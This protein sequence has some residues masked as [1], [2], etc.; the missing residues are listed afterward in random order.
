MSY[1]GKFLS[2]PPSKPLEVHING[3]MSKTVNRTASEVARVAA[4]F[5]DLGKLNPNFQRKLFGKVSE[6]SNHSLLSAV[7]L[8]CFVEQNRDTLKQWFGENA[9]LKFKMVLA[10]IIAHHGNLPNFREM[11][12]KD[13]NSAIDLLSFLS[14][15]TEETIPAAGFLQVI[16]EEKFASFSILKILEHP[17]LWQLF[18]FGE[19]EENTW[20]IYAL[21]YFLE[22]QFSFASLIESD[23]RDAGN[24]EDF[25]LPKQAKLTAAELSASID[26]TFAGL[27]TQSELNTL[28]TAI[29]EEAVASLKVELTKGSRVFSLTAPT[30]AGKTYTLLALAKEIQR[31]RPE[32][33]VLYALPFLS[34]IEQV[35]DITRGLFAEE[36]AVL[37]F[38][39]KSVNTEIERAQA[40]LDGDQSNEKVPALLKQD[41]AANTFDHPFIVTTFVQFFETLMSNHNSTL[42]K[43]PNF[44]KR[45]FLIDEIQALP[46]RLYLFFAGW[47]D[48]FCRKFDAYCV[49]ST[50]TMPHW[51]IA[52]FKQEARHLFK[53]YQP[54]VELLEARKF[55]DQKPFNRYRVDWMGGDSIGLDDLAAEVRKQPQS[56]LVILNT[57]DDTKQL[58]EKLKD[59]T[60]PCILLNTHFI[61]QDRRAKIQRAKSLLSQGEKLTLISTQLI[62]AGVDVDFPVIY[63]DLCPLP[64]LI[65]SAGRC[66]RNGR[67]DF[68]QVYFM[69]LKK[70]NGKYGSSLVY[71]DEARQFLEFSLKH[72]KGKTVEEKDLFDIQK[73]FFKKIGEGMTI[74]EYKEGGIDSMI[75]CVNRAEFKSLGR[76]QLIP[77]KDFGVQVTYFVPDGPSDR[78]YAILEKLVE[79]LGQRDGYLGYAQVKLA[80]QQLMKK[81]ADRLLNIR[82]IDASQA[83]QPQADGVM[84]I[85]CLQDPGFFYSSE[86]GIKLGA[87]ESS[88]L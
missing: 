67:L 78:R 82:L 36:N 11:P 60:T 77:E 68:G 53:D 87:F 47:L 12:T 63:R 29:R 35:E 79:G 17:G 14:K 38:H 34:I 66:N 6:Y 32:V 23:K 4:L 8:V 88:I 55:F 84:G 72:I 40:E 22:T 9:V 27:T 83:P 54:P 65:Q 39:S 70:D 59:D 74:G 80:V 37:A 21:D 49:L 1:A 2:H 44:Q 20:K 19:K 58:Y 86:M 51:E 71:R 33:S 28:R 10:I 69:R 76:F 75:G 85:R 31:E 57:I 46:P 43:L 24:N 26:R 73:A 7:G 25:Y 41:F 30:G 64:S 16:F 81:M 62:E 48:V 3:V 18:H 56:C 13:S 52:E 50:A 61:P 15:Q 42:L 45:I 5:H